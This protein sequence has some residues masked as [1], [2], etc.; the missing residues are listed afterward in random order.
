MPF[1]GY[2][3][4]LYR[5]IA[6]PLIVALLL[7]ITNIIAYRYYIRLL[8]CRTNLVTVICSII[9]STYLLYDLIATNSITYYIAYGI[10]LP[11]YH[12]RYP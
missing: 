3:L 5:N 7:L 1:I 11:Y 12:Y 10:T 4:L 9:I 2:T 8:Y 6:I